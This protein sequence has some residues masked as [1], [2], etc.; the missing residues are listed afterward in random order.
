[1]DGN[2]TILTGWNSSDIEDTILTTV[3]G[4]LWNEEPT[5]STGVWLPSSRQLF[6]PSVMTS[7]ISPVILRI[8]HPSLVEPSPDWPHARHIYGW[9]WDLHVYPLGS[10]FAVVAFYS[11]MCILQL[12]RLPNPRPIRCFFSLLHFLVFLFGSSRAVFL[13][14]DPY[15]QKNILPQAIAAV[16]LHLSFPCLTSAFCMVLAGECDVENTDSSHFWA[17]RESSALL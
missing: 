7:T 5:A 4:S 15:N 12:C 10:L 16:F 3:S 6:I 2:S 9:A 1:M 13:F 14:L 17:V 11:L 8:R